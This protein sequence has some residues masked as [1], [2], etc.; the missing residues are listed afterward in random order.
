MRRFGL[1]T[2]DTLCF[3]V[4]HA[5]SAATSVVL[6]VLLCSVISACQTPGART[7]NR[8]LDQLVD[9]ADIIVRGRV[10]STS[11]QPHPQF[12]NLMTLLVTLHVTDTYK[13]SSQTSLTFRQYVWEQNPQADTFG[14]SKGQEMILFLR[15]VSQYGL[16]SP[17]GLEQGR[18]QVVSQRGTNQ[19]IVLNGRANHGLFDHF[20]ERVQSRG[21]QLSPR[22]R[23]MVQTKTGP[24]LV[25]DFEALIRT[26]SG[27]R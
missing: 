2:L 23:V 7:L 17:A 25:E 27:S 19:K 4:R 24:L 5:V 15:P 13:G 9:E 8:S 20:Q 14:Y 21:L 26:L 10:V 11:F 18:F 22:S 12:N 1:V 6:C 3:Y 16:T